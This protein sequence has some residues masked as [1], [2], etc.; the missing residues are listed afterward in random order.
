MNRRKFMLTSIGAGSIALA[1][2]IEPGEQ[3]SE[4]PRPIYGDEDADLEL[5]VYDDFA[6]PACQDFVLNHKPTIISEY[7]DEGLVNIHHYDWP[8]PTHNRWS[9]EMANTARAVQDLEGEDEF[10][11][12]TRLLYEN[13][14]DISV[15]RMNQ[16]LEELELDEQADE[17]L[18]R[19]SNS[20]YQPVIDADRQNGDER[21]VEGTPTVFLDG[22]DVESERIP[23]FDAETI[24]GVLDAQLE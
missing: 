9:S 14:A 12:F 23:S 17:I 13:Q 21:G 6:C 22:D 4:L 11:E 1:G 15:D 24:S 5:H 10:F 16:L 18:E 19:G 7:V 8:I 3:V 2:C 20:V